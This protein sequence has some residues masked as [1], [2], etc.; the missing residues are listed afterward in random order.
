MVERAA[1]N[2]ND[3]WRKHNEIITIRGRKGEVM[4]ARIKSTS[5]YR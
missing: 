4:V 3:G 1:E 5:N 2:G